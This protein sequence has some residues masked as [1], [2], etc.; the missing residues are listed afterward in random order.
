[1]K[2]A[3]FD[4]V[5]PNSLTEAT[6][7]LAQGEEAQLLAGGQSLIPMMNLRVAS[8]ALVIDIAG[9]SEL[10]TFSE[11]KTSVCLG[12]CVTHAAIEDCRVPDP[13]R[14]LMPHVASGLSYRAVSTR[15]TIGGSLALADPAAEW[16][17]VLTALGAQVTLSSNRSQRNLSV[18]EL[19]TG[20]YQTQID[21][22]VLE[23]IEIPKLSDRARWGYVKLS[24]KSGAFA[25]S[26]AAVVSDSARSHSRAVLGAA[27]GAPI[28]LE[29]TSRLLEASGSDLV[30]LEQ[31][32]SSD[33]AAVDD[34]LFD[35]YQIA[36]HAA[37][38]AR[39]AQQVVK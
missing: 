24:R 37:T 10:T 17:T 19:I 4:Y 23:N 13:S 2:P 30:L 27:N 3:L 6:N 20:I 31:A 26:I 5:K 38:I 28:M 1:M 35:E 25:N 39:A 18:A 34:R 21:S 15:G 16:P 8:P 14:G 29:H 32:I 22:E 11:D 7:L 33:L 9:L 12:A 36:A